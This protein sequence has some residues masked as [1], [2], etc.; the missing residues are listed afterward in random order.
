[1]CLGIHIILY[2]SRYEFQE[3]LNGLQALS[4]NFVLQPG[5]IYQMNNFQTLQSYLPGLLSLTIVAFSVCGTPILVCMGL[6]IK[7]DPIVWLP[8]YNSYMFPM[9]FMLGV[10]YVAEAFRAVTVAILLI[11][12]ETPIFSYC[13]EFCK[14][15]RLET[16]LNAYT[17]FRRVRNV[18]LKQCGVFTSILLGF[19]FLLMVLLHSVVIFGSRLLPG[20][21]HALLVVGIIL[22]DI[23]MLIYLPWVTRIYDFSNDIIQKWKLEAAQYDDG[24]RVVFKRKLLKR[25]VATLQPISYRCGSVG[26]L[27][28]D[29]KRVYFMSIFDGVTNV[30]LTFRESW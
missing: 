20:M 3:A 1:M 9:R 10:F 5:Q 11:S 2:F 23:A 6:F 19:L 28:K 12:Y 17:L 30:V 24:D 4:E 29:T 21:L 13:L 26:F 27:R 22:I 15:Q 18:N 16:A 7:I 8:G 14:V 25:Q